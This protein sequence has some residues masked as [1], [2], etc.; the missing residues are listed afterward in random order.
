MPTSHTWQLLCSELSEGD[1]DLLLLRMKAYKAIKSQLMPCTVLQGGVTV[2][3][4]LMVFQGA[5][6][7]G[8][9]DGNHKRA[10]EALLCS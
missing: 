8:S 5:G 2:Y 3:K 4:V 7:P 9:Q 6:L 10:W 1:A